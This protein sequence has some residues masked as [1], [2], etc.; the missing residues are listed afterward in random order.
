MNYLAHAYLSFSKTGILAGNLI[1]D[2]VKGKKQYDYSTAILHGIKLHR[3]IDAFT[4]SHECI[5]E[6]KEFFRADYRLYAAV[7]AD[8]V[9]DYFLAND[10]NEFPSAQSLASFSQHTYTQLN[11]QIE[12]L[13]ENFQQIFVYMKQHDWLYNYRLESGIQHSFAGVVRR[14]L[15]MKESSTAFNIFMHHKDKMQ[16]HYNQFFPLLKKFSQETLQKLEKTV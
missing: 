15:Y 13:P 6:I 2:F 14:S 8:I 12:Q 10:K 3:A 16:V 4:D 1:S 7:F 9:C 11:Q 5:K